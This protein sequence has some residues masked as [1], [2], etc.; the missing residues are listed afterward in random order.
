MAELPFRPF[1]GWIGRASTAT[2]HGGSDGQL[3]DRFV[4]AREEDAFSALLQRYGPMVLQV[5][6]RV[7]PESHDAERARRFWN[8][9]AQ[10]TEA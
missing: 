1:L 9:A 2:A 10:V 5:C 4:A 6:R 7:L 3:L 8:L